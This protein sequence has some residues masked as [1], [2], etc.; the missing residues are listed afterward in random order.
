MSLLLSCLLSYFYATEKKNIIFLLLQSSQI[1][2]KE[3]NS[4]LKFSV[5]KNDLPTTDHLFIFIVQIHTLLHS[6]SRFKLLNSL[7]AVD[8][9]FDVSYFLLIC[10]RYIHITMISLIN[11]EVYNSDNTAFAVARFFFCP[12]QFPSDEFG[13]LYEFKFWDT[14]RD[15]EI[16]RGIFWTWET[17]KRANVR[18]YLLV[19]C[20]QMVMPCKWAW[21]PLRETNGTL[22]HISRTD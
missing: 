8:N 20:S 4:T 2:R 7:P 18:W 14:F 22:T 3:S 5:P 11:F 17:H 21:S 16:I 6:K 15:F 1:T 13:N 9:S 19:F 10:V 12:C